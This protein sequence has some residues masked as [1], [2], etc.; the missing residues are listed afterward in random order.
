MDILGDIVP[1]FCSRDITISSS[2]SKANTFFFLQSRCRSCKNLYTILRM[3]LFELTK[4]IRYRYIFIA[5]AIHWLAAFKDD[6]RFYTPLPLYHTA[7]GCMSAGQMLLFGS[8]LITR[9]KFSA[10]QYFK[11]CQQYKATVKEK[12]NSL[13]LCFI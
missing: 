4:P 2:A 8:T 6:D 9:K 10:S 11:D 12:Q 5:V 13:K 7:G 3:R 1:R